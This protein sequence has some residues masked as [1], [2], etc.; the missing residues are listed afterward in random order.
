MQ[1]FYPLNTT[2]FRK[3]ARVLDNKRL[4]KQALEGWQIMMTLLEL[5]PAGNHRP[6]KGWKNHPAVKMW[7]GHEYGL[8]L[9]VQAMVTEWKRRGFKSTIGEKAEATILTAMR[10]GLIGLQQDWYPDFISKPRLRA[11]V[12][13]SHRVALLNKDY[14]WYSQFNW[15]ED[16]GARPETY[17]YVWPRKLVSA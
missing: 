14:E 15:L 12:A 2:D 17:D 11:S 9:Y 3:I 4:N 16:T 7:E 6:A 8:N 13:A 10:L 5:D 1:T